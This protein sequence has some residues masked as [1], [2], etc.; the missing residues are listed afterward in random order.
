MESSDTAAPANTNQ[1]GSINTNVLSDSGKIVRRSITSTEQLASIIQ[2]MKT[3][4]RER[5]V[6]NGRIAARLAS[7]TPYN[8]NE[9]IQQGLGWMANFSTRPLSTILGRVSPRFVRAAQGMRYVTNSSLSST[10]HKDA[11]RK[12][13]VF[14]KEL[15]KLLRSHPKW[16]GLLDRLAHETSGFGYS[17]AVLPDDIGWMPRPVR[18]DDMFI[19]QGTGMDSCE[20]QL[21]VMYE[22]VLPSDLINRIEDAEI[23]A[24]AGWIIENCVKVINTAKPVSATENTEKSWRSF[25]DLIRESGLMMSYGGGQSVVKLNHA[26]VTEPS[27]KISHYILAGE[28]HVPVF[29]RHDR[30]E[31]MDNA[32]TFFSFEQGN[33]RIHGSMGVGRIAY[34]IA[35]VVDRA[36]NE[37]INR[38]QLSG[39]ILISAPPGEVNKVKLHVSGGIAS[40]SD[41]YS[42]ANKQIEAG[43][44]EFLQLDQFLNGLMN[45]IAGNVTPN[46]PNIKGERVT[47]AAVNLVA[48]REE[49]LRDVRLERF[50]DSFSMMVSM[51]QRRLADP[52]VYSA[53]PRAKAFHDKCLAYM[54]E[55]DYRDLCAEPAS[56]TVED[57]TEQERQQRILQLKEW[58]NDPYVDQAKVR[59]MLAELQFGE[60]ETAEFMP[61]ADD[62]VLVEVAHRQQLLEIPMLE[63]GVDVPVIR[64][65]NHK[66]HI[67]TLLPSL[68]GLDPQSPAFQAGVKHALAHAQASGI[69]QLVQETRTALTEMLKQNA[70]PAQGMPQTGVDM[71]GAPA[72]G[73]PPDAAAPTV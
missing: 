21:V 64:T 24:D 6:K 8:Q 2:Q 23:A 27:G 65:D 54:D 39:K 37:V 17:M 7:E 35:S 42:F 22:E 10:T 43:V 33:G 53:D 44:E 52:D 26:F 55:Q 49:E 72:Q 60:D 47:A 73:M 41:D 36:R 9:L 19:P 46:S 61:E 16:K 40:I 62:P 48:G 29:K 20:A 34:N 66:V 57:Y 4:N 3:E 1:P 70:Q 31:R 59:R 12:S 14:Q 5:S 71:A 25:Q 58:A 63:Q 28:D 67:Q 45:E 69:P 30:F 50:I 38:L 13:R 68:Q 51:I 56:E 11:F 32:A 15:T 18:Q